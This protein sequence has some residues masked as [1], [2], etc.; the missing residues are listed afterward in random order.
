MASTKNERGLGNTF[1]VL[2]HAKTFLS[3]LCSF[4]RHLQ[5]STAILGA[6]VDLSDINEAFSAL[7]GVHHFIAWERP[8]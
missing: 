2:H 3:S 1:A 5:I 4:D 8:V 7:P 6:E